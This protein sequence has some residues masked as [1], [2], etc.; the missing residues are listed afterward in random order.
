MTRHA[1]GTA[2]KGRDFA[3]IEAAIRYLEDHALDR[4]R[5]DEIAG[6][7]DLSPYH[8]HRLF[9]RWAG[10]SPKQFLRFLAVEHAKAM[11]EGAEDVL[12]TSLASGLSGPGRLHDLFVA[13]EAMTPGEYKAGAAR[14]DIRFGY[15]DGPFG[16]YLLAATERGICALSFIAEAGR[17]HALAELRARWPGA[18]IRRDQVYTTTFAHRVFRDPQDRPRPHLKLWLGGTRFQIKVWEALL[19]LPPGH[20]A[21]YGHLA[22]AIGAPKAARAVGRA[23]ADN[24]IAY[25][26]PCHRVIRASGRFDGDYRWGRARKRAMIGW[27][28]AQA[29]TVPPPDGD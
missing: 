1:P 13:F 17:E 22:R 3:R 28:A 7:V 27:E 9:T 25:L 19:R 5:L 8:F 24:P 16:E 14:L 12:E 20:L 29:E 26:I 15:H 2:A 4:P 10:V 11:L 23:L 6:A 21:S 18:A